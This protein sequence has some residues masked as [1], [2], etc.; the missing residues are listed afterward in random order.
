MKVLLKKSVSARDLPRA[1]QEEGRF[2]PDE[3]VSVWVEPDD[4]EFA[5]AVTLDNIMDII[6]RRAQERGLTEE[7][8][9]S[10]LND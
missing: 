2:L 4:P 3:R 8:L 9:E 7:K 6:G 5:A 1:W 10:I